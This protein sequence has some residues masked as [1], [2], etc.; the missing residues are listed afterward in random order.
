M[1]ISMEMTD[2]FG[3]EANYSW[4][5]RKEITIPDNTSDLKI[6]RACKKALEI[7]GVKCIK[8][9]IGDMI[10]LKLINACI[11][12]FITFKEECTE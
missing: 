2:T 6:V 7:T 8:E 3:G 12:V 5:T 4:V 1:K 10:K 11:V 9:D